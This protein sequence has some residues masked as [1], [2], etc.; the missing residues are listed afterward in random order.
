MKQVAGHLDVSE[1][2]AGRFPR[3]FQL[4]VKALGHE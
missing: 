2:V 3:S 4:L 1:K